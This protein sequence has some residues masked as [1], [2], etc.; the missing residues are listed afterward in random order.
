MKQSPAKSAFPM[1]ELLLVML[2]IAIAVGI[3]AANF[4]NSARA[5]VIDDVASQ[6]LS[7]T[8]YGRTQ[9]MSQGHTYRLNF[10]QSDS[11]Y[12]LTQQDFGAAP[13]QLGTEIGQK[14]Q[15]PADVQFEVKVQQ[16]TDGVYVEFGPDGRTMVGEIDIKNQSG[17]LIRIICES[18][19]E[20][21]HI[22]DGR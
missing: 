9:A 15:A 16:Q 3:A 14:F 20:T 13:Q 17:R 7:L 1:L 4:R 8:R 18:P 19:T 5:R 11:S 2:I 6:V 10:N 21:Y 12:W 22:A